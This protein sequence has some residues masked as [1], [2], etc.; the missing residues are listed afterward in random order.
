MF[1]STDGG[2]TWAAMNT[3]LTNLDVLALAI[4]PITPTTLHASTGGGSV[5]DIQLVFDVVPTSRGFMDQLVGTSSAAQT[6]TVTN[7]GLA[8]LQI[9]ATTVGGADPGHSPTDNDTCT[10]TILPT[11]TSLH[12]RRPVCADFWR[13]EECRAHLYE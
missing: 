3:G 7:I 8:D 6:F 12:D 5:F 11:G 1:K 4:D 10:G 2:M 13:N 9:T